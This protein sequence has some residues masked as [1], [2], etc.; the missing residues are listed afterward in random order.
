MTLRTFRLTLKAEPWHRVR[1]EKYMKQTLEKVPCE[2]IVVTLSSIKGE[3]L[4]ILN[5]VRNHAAKRLTNYQ[6]WLIHQYTRT[7]K[8]LRVHS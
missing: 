8:S 6:K 7:K 1:E 4:A 5:T 2:D 3:Q